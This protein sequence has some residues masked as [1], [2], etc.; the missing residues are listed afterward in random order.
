M[1]DTLL[2]FMQQEQEEQDQDQEVAAE[3]NIT[4]ETDDDTYYEN[5]TMENYKQLGFLEF[6]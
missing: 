1:E 3:H 2:E 5:K 6:I 4:D